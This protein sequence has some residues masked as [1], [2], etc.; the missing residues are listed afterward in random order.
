MASNDA[1]LTISVRDLEEV[2]A[3]LR[4]IAGVEPVEYLEW[5]ESFKGSGH[6]CMY[7]GATEPESSQKRY[8]NEKTI[9]P[10]SESCAW[11]Q[12]VKASR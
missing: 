3:L 9:V 12:A 8:T 7:C 4:A 5:I 10:H 6:S 1:V 2:K 11:W